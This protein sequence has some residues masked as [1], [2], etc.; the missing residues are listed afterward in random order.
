MHESVRAVG[1]VTR[2]QITEIIPRNKFRQTKQHGTFAQPVTGRLAIVQVI[3]LAR[4][5]QV[6]VGSAGTLKRFRDGKHLKS[7]APGE[8]VG[9]GTENECVRWRKGDSTS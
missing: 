2:K 9:C 6:I 5:V 1:I 7:F 8:C 3:I 4:Q